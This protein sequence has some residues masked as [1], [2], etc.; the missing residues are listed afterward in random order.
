MQVAWLVALEGLVGYHRLLGLEGVEIARSMA[1]Q[2]PVQARARDVRA[3]ELARDGQQVIQG[4]Q[5][6]APQVHHH[7]LLRRREHG[8]QVMGCVRAVAKDLTLLP[9][10]DGLLGDTKA[11]GQDTGCLAAGCDLGTHG[12][13]GAGVLVQGYQHGLAPGVDCRDSINSCRAALARKSG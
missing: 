2:A 10:V 9:L 6:G 5:Q 8:L 11:L 13:G 12:R 1:A 4:Q 7:D 3:N